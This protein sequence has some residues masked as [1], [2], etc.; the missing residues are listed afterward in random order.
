MSTKRVVLLVL[1]VGA[2]VGLHQLG[3]PPAAASEDPAPGVGAR[4][5]AAPGRVFHGLGVVGCKVVGP[6]V[7]KMVAQTERD[8]EL[9]RRDLRTVQSTA[10]VL[11]NARAGARRIE[12]MDSTALASLD[13]GSPVE[14]FKL[15]M[16]ANGLVAAVHDN[17]RGE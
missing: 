16:Q 15:A 3:V 6:A 5:A 8:L 10:T 17:L 2:L 1:A 11:A 4:L 14:A 9:L 13:E 7:R 12:V